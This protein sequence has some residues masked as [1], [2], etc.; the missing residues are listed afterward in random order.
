M[1]INLFCDGFA[2][3]CHA[4]ELAEA[5]PGN[6][7]CGAK[8]VQQS[9]FAAS[10]DSGDL[11]ERRL[12]QSLG[13]LGAMSVDCKSMGL[14]TQTLQEVEHRVARVERE[15][16]PAW[17]K[18][19]LAAG[20]AVRP[21]GDA[22]DGDIGDAELLEHALRHVQ[23]TLAAIDQY[24]IGPHAAIA[25]RILPERAG[26]AALQ[27]LAHHR[28]VVTAGASLTYLPHRT[29]PRKPGS[30]RTAAGQGGRSGGGEEAADREFAIG[31]FHE[32]VG[33]GDDHRAHRVR[34]LDMAVVVDL[35]PVQRPVE[36]ERRS[37]PVEKLA[38]RSALG[39][40]A[41]E[42]L[43][44]RCEDPVNQPLFVAALRDRE[45]HPAAAERQR[46]LDQLLLDETMA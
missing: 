7:A 46:L 25:L 11:I 13:P 4:L 3:A 33:T 30:P 17:H 43:A 42:R 8:M 16:R 41:A 26:E 19:A 21:F 14:V 12:P 38:L 10:A 23:L 27:D 35:D 34:A 24:E 40:P 36:A 29:L 44:R 18:K 5:G 9:P 15:R 45:R 31:V 22:D 37:H 6:G 1:I 32:P 2:Y 20:I 28:V 39:K